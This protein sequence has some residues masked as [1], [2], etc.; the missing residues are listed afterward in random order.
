M[1]AVELRNSFGIA[2]LPLVECFKFQY[3]FYFDLSAIEQ[4]EVVELRPSLTATKYL[5]SGFVFLRKHWS[6]P[7]IL[8]RSY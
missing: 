3:T 1:H 2:S 4:A 5:Y 7:I 8:I 6:L